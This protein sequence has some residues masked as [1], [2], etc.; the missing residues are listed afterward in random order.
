MSDPTGA[1]IFV[2]G[3]HGF[4]GRYVVRMLA[5]EGYRVV[6]AARDSR[7][8][9]DSLPAD[10]VQVDLAVPDEV[11]AAMHGCDEVIHL[12]ARAGG[13]QFQQ[14]G[15]AIFR[16]NRAITDSV[17]DAAVGLNIRRMFVASSAV[18]YRSSHHAVA[19]DD[20]LLGPI[21]L[22]SPYAWSKITDEVAAQWITGTGQLDTVI[23]RFGNVY[24]PGAPFDPDRS[25]VVHALIQRALETPA[26]G[27]LQ[28]WGDGSAVRSFI[29][30]EDVAWAI[31]TLLQDGDPGAAYN[32]D[33]GVAVTIRDLAELVRQA[34]DPSIQLAFDS[35]KPAGVPYRVT[36]P[37]RL[38]SLGFKATM[39][40]DDGIARTVAGRRDEI[41]G[42]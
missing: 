38:N 36:D 22:P 26:G 39:N 40:L 15:A 41:G 14:G 17:I 42:S 12:A 27:V 9:D 31:L 2:T 1:R 23:G 24:G 18:V 25:T 10:I 21:D 4:I 13:I 32:V 20:A 30:V 29:Y 6:A 37:A 5:G 28:V 3:A 16:E 35:T 8:R 11:K 7:D 34:V 33:S 19:E